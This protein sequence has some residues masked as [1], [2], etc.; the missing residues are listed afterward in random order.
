MAIATQTNRISEEDYLSGELDGEIRHEFIDGEIYAMAGAKVEHNRISGNIFRKFGNHLEGQS[1][2]PFMSDMKV[3]VES[4][5]YYPDILVDCSD[6]ETGSVSTDNPVIIIEVLSESTR[7]YDSTIKKEAYLA[8]DSLQEYALIEPSFGKVE[9]F[10]RRTDWRSESF[11]LG[12]SVT[13]ETI[14][15]TLSVEEIYDRVKNEDT[16]S[17]MKKKQENSDDI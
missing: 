12:D 17:F 9:I 16:I 1:C 4:N 8:L 13:F 6:I 15:L 10:R 7:R 2:E 3:K 14:N 5:Y 11:F